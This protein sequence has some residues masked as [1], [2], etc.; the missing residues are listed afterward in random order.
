VP[1]A[2]NG[3]A[4]LSQ[5]YNRFEQGDKRR[6]A[7]YATPHSPVNPGK[8]INVGFLAGQQYNL[9][10]DSPLTDR[11]GSPLIFI[12]EVKNIETGVNLEVTGIRPIKYFPDYSNYFSPDNDFVYFRL[13]DLLLMKVEAILRGGTPTAAGAYGNTALSI[14]NAIRTDSSRGATAFSSV[15]LDNLLEERGR[16][17]WWEGWRRQDLIRFKKFLIPFQEKN[18]QS[19]PKYLLFP[20]PNDQLSVNPYLEQN[21]GY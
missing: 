17:L 6:E 10:T 1:F 13:P 9:N 2:A 14:I 5:F 8:R 16:E 4:T 7:V 11:L 12:P 18:Y 21:P 19:D 15:N 3:W 20:I